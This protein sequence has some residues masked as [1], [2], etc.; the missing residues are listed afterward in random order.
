M[1]FIITRI[2]VIQHLIT[3]LNSYEKYLYNFIQGH[4]PEYY[5]LLSDA[6][7][8]INKSFNDNLNTYIKNDEP[9]KLELTADKLLN[10]Y[11]S[12][13]L[14]NENCKIISKDMFNDSF[15]GEYIKEQT[16]SSNIS[17]ITEL[18][19]DFYNTINTIDT[20]YKDDKSYFTEQLISL[21]SSYKLEDQCDILLQYI[22]KDLDNSYLIAK[23]L[24]HYI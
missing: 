23:V 15:I 8:E 10:I 14:I 7:K 12:I 20:N 18:K 5:K 1:E 24:N 13:K 9:S 3:V 2:K 11:N 17:Q 22:K 4:N 21:I 19:N 16:S 6:V